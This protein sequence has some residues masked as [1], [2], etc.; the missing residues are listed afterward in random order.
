[1]STA[2][3][4]SAAFSARYSPGQR[5]RVAVLPE[6][7]DAVGSLPVRPG[8]PAV[9]RPVHLGGV[10]HAQRH[11]RRVVGCAQAVHQAAGDAA[12]AYVERHLGERHSLRAVSV[13]H[14]LQPRGYLVERLAPGH[15]LPLRLAAFAHVLQRHGHAVGMQAVRIHHARLRADG[16]ECRIGRQ[17]AQPIPVDLGLDPTAPVAEHAGRVLRLHGSPSHVVHRHAIPPSRQNIRAQRRRRKGAPRCAASGLITCI[18]RPSMTSRAF[19]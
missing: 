5:S 12:E 3:R 13:R 4:S 9:H 1:M 14:R 16:R 15:L 6:V 11:R 8:E 10:A 2:P 7:D 19:S 17:H 18:W